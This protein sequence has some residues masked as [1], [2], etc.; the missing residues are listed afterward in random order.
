MMTEAY[1]SEDVPLENLVKACHNPVE[2]FKW[3]KDLEQASIID[4]VNGKI[5]LWY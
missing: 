2:K 3:D 1:F 5:M 4:I